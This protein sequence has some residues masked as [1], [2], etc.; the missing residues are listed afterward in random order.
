MAL[1]PQNPSEIAQEI[2]RLS[3]VLEGRTDE[4]AEHIAAAAHASATFKGTH[5]RALLNVISSHG[6]LTVG[7]KDAFTEIEVNEQRV[8]AE[9]LEARA[10]ATKSSM[11]SLRTQI[12]ALRSLGA[13]IRAQT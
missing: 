12:D 8:V 4:Y 9:V 5:A 1:N 13:S 10:K 3:E 6:K 2:A 7:E 11:D